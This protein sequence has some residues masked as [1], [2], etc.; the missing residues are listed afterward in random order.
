M[1][2]F[3]FRR[4][5]RLTDNTALLAAMNSGETLPMF[6]LDPAQIDQNPYFNERSRDF[7]IN[8]L[9]AVRNALR[10]N[11]SDILILRGDPAVVVQ[12][13]IRSFSIER[14]FFNRD[15]TPFSKRRDSS[16]VRAAQKLGVG[17]EMHDDY[18]LADPEI[19]SEK[20]TPYT[21]FTSFYRKALKTGFRNPVTGILLKNLCAIPDGNQDFEK[22]HSGG[23]E[24]G[25]SILDT[26]VN[27]NKNAYANYANSKVSYFNSRLS[28][29]IKFGTLSIREVATAFSTLPNGTSLLRQLYW[30]DFF[31]YLLHH[32]PYAIKQS[33]NKKL[34]QFAWRNE[35][36]LIEA[37]KKG[38]TG[39]P[40]IDAAMRDLNETGYIN[41]RMR[42]IVSSFLVK[43][44][45]TDWRIGEHYFATKLVDY[46]PASNNGNWQ[47]VASTGV[48]PRGGF[49]TFNPWLQQ[50]RYDPEC[51]YI[52]RN[53]SELAEVEPYVIHNI[54]HFKVKDYPDPIVDHVAAAR[55]FREMYLHG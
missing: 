34:S 3:I 7:M 24:E 18:L 39:F 15:Y 26:F 2:L 28:P 33:F 40:I 51:S 37:W 42:L 35:R 21:N 49:R 44:L 45:H 30:R 4:D 53:V 22:V 12:D 17:V 5:L 36:P 23:T 54:Q 31:L 27:E 14:I 20:G 50:R 43:D 19:K 6:I 48:D 8:S 13:T 29:H 55:E 38:R 47:W 41:N 1:N 11:G 25:R 52:R 32:F 46:D 9:N 16:I 10:R